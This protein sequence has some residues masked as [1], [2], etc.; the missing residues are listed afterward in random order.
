MSPSP[1]NV[2]CDSSHVRVTEEQ[3]RFDL[4]YSERNKWGRAY[5]KVTVSYT[6]LSLLV[7]SSALARIWAQMGAL[8]L[9]AAG[10]IPSGMS[11]TH[12]WIQ[13][14]DWKVLQKA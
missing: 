9:A 12:S 10:R 1:F 11:G 7:H 3:P 13:N 6:A 2:S 5:K 4:R 8:C 14:Q